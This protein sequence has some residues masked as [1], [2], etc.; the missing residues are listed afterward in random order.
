MFLHCTTMQCKIAKKKKNALACH[1]RRNCP[2]IKAFSCTMVLTFRKEESC[3]VWCLVYVI[4]KGRRVSWTGSRSSSDQN[5]YQIELFLWDAL[6]KVQ[7]CA[8]T[9]AK[10]AK[11]K[12]QESNKKEEDILGLQMEVITGPNQ[13]TRGPKW[14]SYCRPSVTLSL[15]DQIID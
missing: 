15:M 11:N 13:L 5:I 7:V 14:I 3:K 9:R 2:R 10:E 4:F 6:R 12:M 8:W 1:V